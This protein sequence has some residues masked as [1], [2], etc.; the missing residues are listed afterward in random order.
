MRFNN[1]ITGN[2]GNNNLNGGAGNDLLIGGAG[3]DTL[4]GGLGNDTFRFVGLSGKDVVTDFHGGVGVV[5]VLNL[6]GI[7]GFTNFAQV[8]S[9]STQVGADTVIT[10]D[11]NDSIVLSGVVKTAVVADDFTFI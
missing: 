11:A 3:N 2:S 4:T 10:F 6:S 8:M 5:D 7:S 1:T 9:H